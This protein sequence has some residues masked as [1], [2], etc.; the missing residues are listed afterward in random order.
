[1][2]LLKTILLTSACILVLSSCIGDDEGGGGTVNYVKVG[3]T[4]PSFTVNGLD[5]QVSFP[6][7]FAGANRYL[8][9]FFNS[10]CPSCEDEMP[11][12]DEVWGELGDDPGFVLMAIARDRNEGNLEGSVATFMRDYCPN[13]YD[14][15]LYYKDSN[16]AAFLKFGNQ[17]IPRV[18]VLDGDRKIKA[19]WVGE[20]VTAAQLRAALESI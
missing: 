10:W 3:D 8:I 17:T 4:A 14:D 12:V 2:K 9:A 7:D 13:I 18:Y 20:S 1:M 6:G 5:G 16:Q 15:G 11:K 19:M